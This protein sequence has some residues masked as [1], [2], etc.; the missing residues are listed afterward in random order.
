MSENF[1][2]EGVG[3]GGFLRIR[4]LL[5]NAKNKFE[6]IEDHGIIHFLTG[7]NQNISSYFMTGTSV[8]IL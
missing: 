7:M 1:F 4:I 2:G 8:N 6:K 3:V 5:L